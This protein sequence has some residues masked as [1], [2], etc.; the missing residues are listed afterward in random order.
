MRPFAGFNK[1]IVF[2]FYG[3]LTSPTKIENDIK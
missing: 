2:L 3:K 1:T